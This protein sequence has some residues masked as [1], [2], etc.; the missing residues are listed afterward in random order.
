LRFLI[1]GVGGFAGSHLADYLLAKAGADAEV[2]GCDLTDVP[3]PYHPAQLKRLV[4]NLLDP[5]AVR[6]LIERVRP[7]RIYHLAGQAFVGDSWANPWPTL[8]TNLRSQVNLSE[9]VLAARLEPRLLVLGSAEEYGRVAL[10]DLQDR[11]AR[12]DLHGRLEVRV[13]VAQRKD[14]VLHL[15]VERL[16]IQPAFHLGAVLGHNA[17]PV[18]AVEVRV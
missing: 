16:G 18:Q 14:E 5:E 13:L 4:C 10:E 11:V 6:A 8:E 12:G 15:G 7:D 1:T 2:W 17:R 9:A 3:R